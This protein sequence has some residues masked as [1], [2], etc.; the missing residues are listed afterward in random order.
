VGMA[1][2]HFLSNDETLPDY[3]YMETE[4]IIQLF[5]AINAEGLRGGFIYYDAITNDARLCNEVIDEAQRIAG[6]H[7]LNYCEMLSAE[8]REKTVLIQ[9]HDHLENTA[10][11]F[12]ARYVINASG[13]WKILNT[14]FSHCKNLRHR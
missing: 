4:E 11:T 9:A 7:A 14:L 10:R 2:Y 5:P 6:N 8:K 1:I 12:E 13:V 3:R